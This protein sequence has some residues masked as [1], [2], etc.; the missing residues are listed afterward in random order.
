MECEAR[1][2]VIAA[3]LRRYYCHRGG[4]AVEHLD[5]TIDAFASGLEI[6][7]GDFSEAVRAI[8]G[9]VAESSLACFSFMGGQRPTAAARWWRDYLFILEISSAR[10]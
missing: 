6:L 5:D 8:S 3:L 9:V 7:H 2:S 10:G 1:R 4:V